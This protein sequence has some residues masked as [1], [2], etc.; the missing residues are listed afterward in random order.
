MIERRVRSRIHGF[1]WKAIFS[2]GAL[3]RISNRLHEQRTAEQGGRSTAA[4]GGLRALALHAGQKAT[5]S[6]RRHAGGV[7]GG[8]QRQAVSCADTW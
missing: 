1:T 6:I 2:R 8:R 4:S 7:H 5:A 3:L